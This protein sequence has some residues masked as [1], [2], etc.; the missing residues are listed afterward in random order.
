RWWTGEWQECSATC[1][2]TGEKKRTVLCIRT[3]GSDEQALPSGD[4]HHL[5]RPKS[6]F[7]CN[8]DISCPSDWSVSNWTQCTVT[9]GGGIRT[10]NVTCPKY[11]ND[12]C[13]PSKKPYSK[14]LCG[15]QQ[16]PLQKTSGQLPLKYKNLQTT[17]KIYPKITDG[18]KKRFIL[19][20]K[21]PKHLPSSTKAPEDIVETTPISTPASQLPPLNSIEDDFQVYDIPNSTHFNVVYKYN[22][23]LV[24][25][26]K[27]K[28]SGNL[29]KMTPNAKEVNET[30]NV[31]TDNVTQS[32]LDLV[33]NVTN[34]PPNS[35][36]KVPKITPRYDFL[37]QEPETRMDFEESDAPTEEPDIYYDAE[38]N[39]IIESRSKRHKGRLKVHQENQTSTID[40]PESSTPIMFTTE[41]SRAH[42]LVTTDSPPENT[43]YEDF[44]E[45][46]PDLIHLA[47]HG[48]LPGPG[49]NIS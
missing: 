20:K 36:T 25:N 38:N 24:S 5:T 44:T 6:Y 13:D 48:Q 27:K 45:Q 39:N 7:S 32:D 31:S 43:S 14:A 41:T 34:F 42:S 33:Y 30:L 16:C 22:F 18:S 8:R 10:R 11:S 2:P 12:S 4:C 37:T 17:F 1:G 21:S 3:V 19:I 35:T 28:G 9:C 49:L 26:N 15:L 47:N 46:D 29:T 40:R 23:V